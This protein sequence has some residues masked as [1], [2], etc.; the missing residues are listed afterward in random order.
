VITDYI[1]ADPGLTGIYHLAS[2]PIS[3]YDLLNLIKEA[4]QKPITVIPDE[5]LK[6]DRSLNGDRF[7]RFTGYTPPSWEELISKMHTDYCHSTL[8]HLPERGS[9][10]APV[11]K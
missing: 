10:H 3:K 6:I 7:N 1:V 4:Y 2:H 5:G 8:Y 9:V 11:K